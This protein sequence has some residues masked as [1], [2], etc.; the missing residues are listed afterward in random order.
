MIFLYASRSSGLSAASSSSDEEISIISLGSDFLFVPVGVPATFPFSLF[1]CTVAVE[2]DDD[3][4]AAAPFSAL[5]PFGRE[6][7]EEEATGC[8]VGAGAGDAGRGMIS[9]A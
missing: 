7:E 6:E 1:T 3:D 8:N 9:R 4:A 5:T 2:D